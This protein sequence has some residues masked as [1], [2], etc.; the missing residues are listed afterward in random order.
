MRTHALAPACL[1][2]QDLLTHQPAEALAWP[3][4]GPGNT[5][6]SSRFLPP[7]L[8]ALGLAELTH[9]ARGNQ[10]RAL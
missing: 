10:M 3:F 6:R 8:E 2:R 4:G 1:L 5:Q 7:L 9:E